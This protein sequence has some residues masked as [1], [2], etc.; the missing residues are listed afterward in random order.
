MIF[1]GVCIYQHLA[2]MTIPE[3][4]L[5][6]IYENSLKTRSAEEQL[7]IIDQL[8]HDHI[9]KDLLKAQR[10]AGEGLLLAT[11]EKNDHYSSIFHSILGSVFMNQSIYDL[12]LNEFQLA[13]TISEKLGETNEVAWRIK[14]I[15]D[16]YLYKGVLDLAMEKYQSAYT[17]FHQLNDSY[18]MSVV[19]N[20]QGLVFRERKNHQSELDAV[21]SSKQL[22]EELGDSLAV[23][24]SNILIGNA[25]TALDQPDSAI[26][27][28]NAM[29]P[30]LVSKNEY[31]LIRKCLIGLS[32]AWQ[33][34]V[35]SD[36]ALYY[37]GQAELF[38][39]KGGLK[40][41]LPHIY[42]DIAK[43][44]LQLNN[45]KQALHYLDLGIAIASEQNN[46]VD[47]TY[48]LFDKIKINKM[49][50]NQNELLKLYDE[51]FQDKI[52]LDEQK[53]HTNAM[54]TELISQRIQFEKEILQKNSELEHAQIVRRNYSIIATLILIILVLVI[55]RY[56]HKKKTMQELLEKE[57]TIHT[58]E[59]Q[60]L[61][62]EIEFKHRELLAKSLQMTQEK[63]WMNNLIKEIKSNNH[64]HTESKKIINTIED[65]LSAN[66]DWNEFEQWFTNIHSGFLSNLKAQYPDLI[67]RE[68]ELCILLKL[69]MSTKE[70]ANLTHL[71]AESIEVYRSKI[72]RKLKLEKG[73][74]LTQFIQS[75][76]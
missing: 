31:S 18:G 11:A 3:D 5:E 75:I 36:S 39:Q 38:M 46:L 59:K 6:Y 15:G 49:L 9:S 52:R 26:I 10:L 13:K 74:N 61:K 47:K 72:R 19:L 32:T 76:G 67:K 63:E 33:K 56:F 30:M 14:S 20:D 53:D 58:L 45:H 51:Y 55:L 7:Y 62:N 73:A 22:R 25:L 42:Q 37:L 60:K 48:L 66:K 68:I 12:A 44:H 29:L 34:K 40:L 8:A 41:Y 54:H 28:F 21:N 16:V 35:R 24:H 17:V 64:L 1:I 57:E 71:S 4:S 23:A 50:N 70:I 27:I 43:I 69:E 65:R 2:G